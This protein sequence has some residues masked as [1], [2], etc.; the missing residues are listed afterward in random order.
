MVMTSTTSFSETSGSP[1][2]GGLTWQVDHRATPRLPR[3]E[4]VNIADMTGR[5]LCFGETLDISAGGVC[6]ICDRAPPLDGVYKIKFPLAHKG[7]S[8][9]V[10]AVM[11]LVYCIYSDTLRG[12]QIGFELLRPQA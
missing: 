7:R 5:T 2:L 3:H 12:F 1:D 4:H 10:A 11:K 9:M 6:V 8:V